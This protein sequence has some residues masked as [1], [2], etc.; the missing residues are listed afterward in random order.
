[1]LMTDPQSGTFAAL[2]KLWRYSPLRRLWSRGG[3]GSR[4]GAVAIQ[5]AVMLVAIIAFV[6]LGTEITLALMT[7]RHMQSAADAAALAAVSARASGYPADYVQEALALAAAEGFGNDPPN[8]VEVTALSSDAL[9][10]DVIQQQ[11]LWLAKLV[12]SNDLTL[13]AQG[14]ARVSSDSGACV[15][16]LDPTSGQSL[17]MVGTSSATFSG[18][19]VVVNSS[20]PQAVSMVGSSYLAA[21]H[22]YVTGGYTAPTGAINAMIETQSPRETLS[23]AAVADGLAAEA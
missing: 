18:C 12:Y 3:D 10:V 6:S 20:S 19:D 14:Q 7:L 4:R 22:L 23:N 8:S 1:M 11:P 15:L 5:V 16:A 21:D 2:R 13:H 9:I 17:Q